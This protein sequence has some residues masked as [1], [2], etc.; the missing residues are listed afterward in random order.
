[1][2]RIDI[3]VDS[4][5]WVAIKEWATEGLDVCRKRNDAPL[6]MENTAALRG[7]IAALKKLLALETPPAERPQ[8]QSQD[9][10]D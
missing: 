2:S 4:Q 10:G 3:Q 5:T 6:P 9:H 1:M 8:F 7:E